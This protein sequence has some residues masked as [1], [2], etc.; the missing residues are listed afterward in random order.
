VPITSVSAA[1]GHD[2]AGRFL[3]IT[4][5]SRHVLEAYEISIGGPW[6]GA[7]L[8]RDDCCFPP[9]GHGPVPA[10]DVIRVRLD[11]IST[12]ALASR[13]AA[14]SFAMFSDGS[15]EGS[16]R[17][18]DVVMRR[19][20]Q[21]EREAGFWIGTIDKVAAGPAAAAAR[22]LSVYQEARSK[23][24]DVSMAVLA[25]LGIP[26]LIKSAEQDPA[27]FP[28]AAAAARTRIVVARDALTLRL[29]QPRSP[30]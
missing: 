14:V 15:F 25:P 28:D 30:R 20:A 7:Y 23:Y 19:R 16:S 4:N 8:R 17:A 27:H 11:T 13:H 3:A 1:I 12:P 29:A 5:R 24:D 9:S 22:R 21:A 6:K 2:D 26:D 10:G 18:R